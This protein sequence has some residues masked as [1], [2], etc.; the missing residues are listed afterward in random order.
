MFTDSPGPTTPAR[1]VLEDQP[2]AVDRGHAR[3]LPP[4]AEEDVA[5]SGHADPVARRAPP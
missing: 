2:V 5:R 4:V 3:V 1:P